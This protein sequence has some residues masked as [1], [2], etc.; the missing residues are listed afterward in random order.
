MLAG[1]DDVGGTGQVGLDGAPGPDPVPRACFLV[2]WQMDRDRTIATGPGSAA[3]ARAC[4]PDRRTAIASAGK[5]RK[6]AAGHGFGDACQRGQAPGV[7][8]LQPA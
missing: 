5:G 1:P 8:G 2:G 6:R 7:A 3:P 4:G